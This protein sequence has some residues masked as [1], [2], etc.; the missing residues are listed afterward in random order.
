MCHWAGTGRGDPWGL[1]TWCKNSRNAYQHPRILSDLVC[2]QPLETPVCLAGKSARR[3]KRQ[4]SGRAVSVVAA[5]RWILSLRSAITHECYQYI[6]RSSAAT[7]LLCGSPRWIQ[8]YPHSAGR[9]FTTA[10]HILEST[11]VIWGAILIGET[12]DL[13]SIGLSGG[14]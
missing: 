3:P 4:G 7:N 5:Q 9:R 8:F 13:V 6:A 2:L 11:G 1:N 10:R 14:K 12:S